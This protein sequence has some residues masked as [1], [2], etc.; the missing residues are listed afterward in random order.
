MGDGEFMISS[1]QRMDPKCCQLPPATLEA[2]NSGLTAVHGKVPVGQPWGGVKVHFKKTGSN[3][4]NPQCW[5]SKQ[6]KREASAICSSRS[7]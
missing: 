2:R 7:L 4:K 1:R 6:R 3:G 5:L